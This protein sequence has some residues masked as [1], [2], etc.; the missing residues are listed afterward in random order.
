V[1]YIQEQGDGIEMTKDLENKCK[2]EV[3]IHTGFQEGVGMIGNCYDCHSTRKITKD[4]VSKSGE[5]YLLNEPK[6]GRK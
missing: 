6:K 4:Y 3:L 1:I 5:V 2:H